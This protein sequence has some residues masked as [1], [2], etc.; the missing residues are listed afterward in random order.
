MAE[1][2]DLSTVDLAEEE[3]YKDLRGRN[4][5]KDVPWFGG[6]GARGKNPTALWVEEGS[7][8]A[9]GAYPDRNSKSRRLMK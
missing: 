3:T 9:K 8:K 7:S 4:G 2:K 5:V 6:S 1:R